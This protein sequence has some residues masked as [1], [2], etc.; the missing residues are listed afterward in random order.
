[1]Y[2]PG[3]FREE[4]L[5]VIHAAMHDIAFATLVTHGADGMVATHLPMFVIPDEGPYGTLYGHV[6]RGNAQ[7]RNLAEEALVMFT[8]PYAYISPNWYP[9]K[10]E[11]GKEVPTWN[12]IA[13]HAYGQAQTI[14]DPVALRALL[15]RLT[16]RHEQAT[17]PKPWHVDDAPADYVQAMLKGIVG[18]K[19]PIARI[20]GKWKLS[21]NR[22]DADR[23][24][25]R[26][27]LETMSGERERALA[28]QMRQ[29]EP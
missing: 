7:W 17:Q 5:P 16:D 21:Q 26:V 3:P 12:Y 29:T 27:G 24:G 9:G 8:G 23:I 14:E 2:N 18:L 25:A 13:V 6:A 11:H 22:N 20:E 19:I 15:V 4:R 1:M 28:A 10:Q